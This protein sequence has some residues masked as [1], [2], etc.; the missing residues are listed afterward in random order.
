MNLALWLERTAAV[1]GS[2][3]ALLAGGEV[4]AD[5]ARFHARAAAFAAALAAPPATGWRSS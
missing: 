4:V 1:H 2:A 3:P 5:Y